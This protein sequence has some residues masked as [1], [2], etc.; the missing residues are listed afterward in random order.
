VEARANYEGGDNL[1]ELSVKVRKGAVN[2]DSATVQITSDLGTA[3]LTGQ[4]GG[5]YGAAQS[6][7]PAQG[8][9]LKVA[10]V[11]AAGMQTDGL[12]ASLVAP[13]RVEMI[14]DAIKPFDPHTLPNQVLTLSWKG[15]AANQAEVR[16]TDFNAG[17]LSPD[18]LTIAIPAQFFQDQNP[19]LSI[20]RENSVVLAGG[21]P[22]STFSA[23]YR[24]ETNLTVIN[25]Y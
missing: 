21:L 5:N 14:A 9:V 8:Y 1:T 10:V 13:L 25:P 16:T 20:T 4:G 2:L 19:K 12:E 24:F 3:M 17:P 11:N 22:G 6:G 7:W 15:P 23:R 18:P